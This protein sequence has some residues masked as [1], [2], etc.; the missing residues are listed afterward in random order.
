MSRQNKQNMKPEEAKQ[1]KDE[2]KD[3][4]KKQECQI[5]FEDKMTMNIVKCP[6]C[7]HT[8]C[9]KCV[10]RFLMELPTDNPRCMNPECKKVWN[11]QFVASVTPKSFHND[12]YR[13]R[14]TQIQQ[15]QQQSL[16]PTTQES[17]QIH[18]E[19]LEIL[20]QIKQIDDENKMWQSLILQN[21]NT[22][23]TL[24]LQLLD[25]KVEEKK[26]QRKYT[27][28]CP[29]VDCR[30]F[31][32]EPYAKSQQCGTCSV[33][34][35]SQCYVP[36]KSKKDEEHKC[37]PDTVKTMKLLEKDTKPCPQC[38]EA[39]YKVSGCDQ[40]YC[41][42]CN[43]AF[44]WK[45]GKIETGVIHNPHYYEMQ[46]K[47]NNGVA[48]RVPG[49]IPRGGV[50]RGGVCGRVN[51]MDQPRQ[52]QR[53]LHEH[54][55]ILNYVFNVIRLKQHIRHVE[56]NKYTEN[57]R[58][59]EHYPNC[60]VDQEKCLRINYLLGVID[61]KKWF[62]TLKKIQKKKE[63]NTEIRNIYTTFL[64]IVTILITNILT[65][66]TK[67]PSTLRD[68]SNIRKYVNVEFKKIGYTYGSSYPIIT[69]EW[70]ISSSTRIQK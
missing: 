3:E 7:P 35:C 43:T 55:K 44:S 25:E 68:I 29:V 23:R 26:E 12:K 34:I 15:E 16:L 67:I 10:M 5:C 11:L 19:K 18:K 33:W 61:K 31:L 30:G 8:C 27:R 38:S 13:L 57:Y 2:V 45:T 51:D 24:R 54:P 50:P 36:K 14:R 65:D 49:D 66:P 46:R 4:V 6:Y 53:L 59:C 32:G 47:M 41:V 63:K 42:T 56:I 70:D 60:G 40:M 17:V 52:L 37:D 9:N 69:L 1:V 62:S 28:A 21:N 58:N 22:I 64:D 48:P 20:D 39:I